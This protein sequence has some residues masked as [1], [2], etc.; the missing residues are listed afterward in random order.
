[1]EPNVIDITALSESLRKS[2]VS[3]AS[4]Y[5]FIQASTTP[6]LSWIVL[7]VIRPLVQ[8]MIT[9]VLNILTVS[10]V[11]EAFFLNTSIRK[12]SQANDY[13]AAVEA[14]NNLP[15]NVSD[16]DY[17]NAEQNEIN[18]FNSFVTLGN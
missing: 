5:V 10:A 18:A 6:G 4:D 16:S 13:V 9:Q 14:K 12:S 7:P 8:F 15:T 11:M 3:W 1:M 2:F 17:E